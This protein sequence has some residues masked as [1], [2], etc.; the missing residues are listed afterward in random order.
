M[1]LLRAILSRTVQRLGARQETAFDLRI[2]A[3]TNVD[4]AAARTGAIPATISTTVSGYEIT[5][6]PQRRRGAADIRALITTILQRFSE[7]RRIAAPLIDSM[8]ME[9]LLTYAAG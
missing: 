7:R 5:V 9:V 2:M 6:P 3:A 4:L 1:K 8:A